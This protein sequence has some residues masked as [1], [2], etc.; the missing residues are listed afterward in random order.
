[1]KRPKEILSILDV[2]GQIDSQADVHIDWPAEPSG[3]WWID[4]ILLGVPVVMSWSQGVGFGFYTGDDGGIDDR[5]N[6]LYSSVAMTGRRLLQIVNSHRA[7]R[8][9]ALGLAELRKL[10]EFSQEDVARRSNVKQ[11][12]ISRVEGRSNLEIETLSS[13]V[14]ALGLQV[15]VQVSAPGIAVNIDPRVHGSKDAGGR[16]GSTKHRK[17]KRIGKGKRTWLKPVE[18][19]KSA[20]S[21]TPRA[22]KAHAVGKAKSTGQG[23]VRTS[24]T[25]RP[26]KPGSLKHV[27]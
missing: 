19:I 5:P 22:G 6:E 14:A 15:R 12:A 1:M 8:S 17:P 25:G 26:S 18:R 23:P 13:F 11:S 7:G 9:P 3:T 2:I 27:E 21:A 4:V 16:R 20:G 10:L 24:R